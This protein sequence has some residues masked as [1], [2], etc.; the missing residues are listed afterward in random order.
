[1]SS[2]PGYYYSTPRPISGADD[3]F[4]FDSGEPSLDEY[5]HK[6][7]L[8]NHVEGAS[9]CFVACREGHVAGFYALTSGGVDRGSAPGAI[10]RNMPEPIPVIL[11]S[12]LAVERKEQGRGLGS[13]LLR[14][15]ITR[16]VGVA[17]QVGVRAI[18]VHALH[19]EAQRFYAHFEFEPSPTDPLHLM[20]SMKDARAL[21][22][23]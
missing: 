14:D 10:R 15:A 4:S 7:A 22:G 21:I 18:L 11:L 1:M 3:F 6:R 8:S 23:L 17:E 19:E 13:H 12:R 16:S 5:L 20:L 2:T 9:R